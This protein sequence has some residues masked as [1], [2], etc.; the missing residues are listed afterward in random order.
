MRGSPP[1]KQ[2]SARYRQIGPSG[3]IMSEASNEARRVSR[4]QEQ[5]VQVELDCVDRR[6]PVGRTRSRIAAR[7]K[8]CQRQG[9]LAIAVGE[10]ENF[11]RRGQVAGYALRASNIGEVLPQQSLF[12][13]EGPIL[14][15]HAGHF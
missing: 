13:C 9:R 1:S 3:E 14:A 4:P 7:S 10:P 15:A 11:F 6:V 2:Q 5:S 8:S 12:F